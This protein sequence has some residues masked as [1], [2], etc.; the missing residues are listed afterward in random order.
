MGYV[1]LLAG[2]LGVGI[3]SRDGSGSARGKGGVRGRGGEGGGVVVCVSPACAVMCQPGKTSIA[4]QRS[5]GGSS[6]EPED[7]GQ[8]IDTFSSICAK[9]SKAGPWA[10][11]DAAPRPERGGVSEA[12]RR[13]QMQS[14]WN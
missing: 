11:R 8:P 2:W 10:P 4:M 12:S 14:H 5:R 9:C 6:E 13:M 7:V 3:S 1:P